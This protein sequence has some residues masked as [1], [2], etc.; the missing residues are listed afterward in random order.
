MKAPTKTSVLFLVRCLNLFVWGE[1]PVHAEKNA[2]YKKNQKYAKMMI[3][4][5]ESLTEMAHNKNLHNGD[6]VLYKI[7]FS[8]N[9]K[10]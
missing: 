5:Y 3:F 2:Y 9:S 4:M 6:C 1:K 8:R 7:N 10:L